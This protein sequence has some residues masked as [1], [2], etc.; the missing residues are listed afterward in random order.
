MAKVFKVFFA[1]FF[2]A[3]ICPQESHVPKTGGKMW[4]NEGLPS[5]EQNVVMEY[6]KNLGVY[7][8]MGPVKKV[9]GSS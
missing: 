5:A 1:L 9:T 7:D 2:T 6:L 8:T 3:K 4:S